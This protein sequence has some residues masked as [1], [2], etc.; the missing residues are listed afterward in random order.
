MCAAVRAQFPP[1]AT[2]LS[3]A[4]EQLA[5]SASKHNVSCNACSAGLQLLSAR[6]FAEGEVILD[7]K[8]LA[9]SCV[10]GAFREV[11]DLCNALPFSS[12]LGPSFYWAALSSLTATQAGD[13]A[14]AF[15]CGLTAEDQQRILALYAPAYLSQRAT[16][17]KVLDIPKLNTTSID[18][19][20]G[21]E[22]G[23]PGRPPAGHVDMTVLAIIEH[24]GLSPLLAP[25]LQTLALVWKYNCFELPPACDGQQ[26]SS[27]GL[28]YEDTPSL[29]LCGDL[30]A[31]ACAGEWLY[32]AR[33]DHRSS[34]SVSRRLG[35]FFLPA[36]CNH[37]CRPTAA[38]TVSMECENGA[39]VAARMVLRALRPVLPGEEVTISYIEVDS[40]M[41]QRVVERRKQIAAGWLFY[42]RCSLCSYA[43]DEAIAASCAH[44]AEFCWSCGEDLSVWI[45]DMDSGPYGPSE[46][47][48]CDGCGGPDLIAEQAYFLHCN[49]CQMD[50]CP[51]CAGDLAR[52]TAVLGCCPVGNGDCRRGGCIDS[53]MAFPRQSQ[54]S[55]PDPQ[56][57]ATS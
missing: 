19:E 42:C 50:W 32:E 56:G 57:N 18:D 22:E 38:Y 7:C 17:M 8:Q 28:P 30:A 37:S 41:C 55:E 6:D 49:S 43:D 14:E 3:F 20:D 53:A 1:G 25:L 9:V 23:S 2:R 54:H 11:E 39:P 10:D 12:F 4:E 47:P 33:Q 40:E 36:L 51:D 45:S 21:P 52:G 13:C 27:S 24:F 29:T 16:G 26:N 44:S 48:F 46:G 35:L 31:D 5:N 34:S 15:H